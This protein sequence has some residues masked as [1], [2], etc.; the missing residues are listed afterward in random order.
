MEYLNTEHKIKVELDIGIAEITIL[1]KKNQL[2]IKEDIDNLEGASLMKY[3]NGL[4]AI[5]AIVVD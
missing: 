4:V 2:Q 3:I 5:N 1:D